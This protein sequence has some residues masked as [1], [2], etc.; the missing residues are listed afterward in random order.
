MSG[1]IGLYNEMLG[2]KRCKYMKTRDCGTDLLGQGNI[3]E[4]ISLHIPSQIGPHVHVNEELVEWTLS[5]T[6]IGI[7]HLKFGRQ[8]HVNEELVVWTLSRTDV[9]IFHLK[10]GCHEGLCDQAESLM[11]Q[12]LATR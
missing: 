6:D 1:L 12:L 4:L 11:A 2:M 9:G 5:R 3:P 7:F 10:F 8:I